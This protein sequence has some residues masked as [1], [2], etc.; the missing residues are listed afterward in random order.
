VAIILS[1]ILV[2]VAVVDCLALGKYVSA[3]V[4]IL[5]YCES[6]EVHYLCDFLCTTSIDDSRHCQR[7]FCL[8]VIF[9]ELAVSEY[10]VS[11]LIYAV[12]FASFIYVHFK[13]NC[14]EKALH[15]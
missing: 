2:V 5:V 9:T 12:I 6:V 10:V 13:G 8:S 7:L 11:C 14:L 4:I 1:V 3:S 15:Y